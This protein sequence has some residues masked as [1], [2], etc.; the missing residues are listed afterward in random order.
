[1]DKIKVEFYRKLNEYNQ[2]RDYLFTRKSY[3][4]HAYSLLDFLLFFVTASILLILGIVLSIINKDIFYFAFFFALSVIPY[5]VSFFIIMDRKKQIKKIDILLV[6]LRNMINQFNP[7]FNES[8]L[9]LDDYVNDLKKLGFELGIITFKEEKTFIL[10]GTKK[11]IKIITKNTFF[12]N[13]IKCYIGDV[14]FK[15]VRNDDSK[16]NQLIKDYRFDSF[17]MNYYQMIWSFY[18]YILETIEDYF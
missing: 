1:M 15:K 2:E 14:D 10:K 6:E 11:N 7:L 17:N 3:R 12:T 18:K 16:L 13:S 8:K 4:G 9:T 5:S